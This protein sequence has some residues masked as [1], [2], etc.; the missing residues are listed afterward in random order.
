MEKYSCSICG[1]VYD[2]ESADKDRAGNPI[3][4]GDL[5]PD[6]RCSNCGVTPD[7]FDK[8]EETEGAES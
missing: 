5:D 7:L 3:P 1:F 6:W 2:E 8:V 4:F